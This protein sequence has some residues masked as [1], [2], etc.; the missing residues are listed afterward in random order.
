MRMVHTQVAYDVGL[1]IIF[2]RAMRTLE[3]RRL[4][5]L[6]PQVCQHRLLPLVQIMATGTL[7]HAVSL[8]NEDFA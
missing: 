7:E 8:V 6:V 2:H 5:A 4:F 1:L 3:S